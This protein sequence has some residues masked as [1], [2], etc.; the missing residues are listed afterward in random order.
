M[1]V[2]YLPNCVHNDVDAVDDPLCDD[3]SVSYNPNLR[4]RRSKADPVH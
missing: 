3:D 4:Y 2:G 1:Y